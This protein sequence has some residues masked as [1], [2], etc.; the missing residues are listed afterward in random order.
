VITKTYGLCIRAQLLRTYVILLHFITYYKLKRLFDL[1]C[2][3]KILNSR[4]DRFYPCRN[5]RPRL[6]VYFSYHLN[7]LQK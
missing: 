5:F 7:L 3:E 2:L 6:F 4:L 1:W